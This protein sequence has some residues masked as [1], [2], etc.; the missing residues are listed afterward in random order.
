MIGTMSGTSADGVDGALVEIDGHGLSMVPRCLMHRHHPYAHGLREAIF[1]IRRSGRAS[2]GELAGLGREISL[3]CAEVTNQLLRESAL[4]AG[5]IEAVA[6]HGQTLYHHPPNTIQWL[7]PALLAARTRCAVISDFR[8][9]DCAAGGQGAPLVPFADF[10]LFRSDTRNRLLLNLGGIANVTYLRAGGKIEEVIAFDTGPANCIA[11]E[12]CRRSSINGADGVGYDPGGRLAASGRV[13]QKVVDAFLSAD[14][15]SNP[16]P[17]S[18][19]GPV[20]W[21]IWEKARPCGGAM[22]LEDEL[23]TACRITARSVALAVR[24]HVPG[25]PD[26]LLIGG[27]GGQNATMIS[28]LKDQL[29]GIPIHTLD[30]RGVDSHS[31]EAVCFALLG[32]A[33]LDRVAAN[34]PNATGAG[35]PVILG[36]ITPRP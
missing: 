18:T 3:A 30:E 35:Q 14:Y 22:T 26:E 16:P 7:D 15:F 4:D 31:R 1:S 29:E 11:D 36:C 13:N 20:M 32:A 23:A 19:D 28:M 6:A 25:R 27:G 24:N 17:K 9:A 5:R 8:R 34:I 12:L 10:I 21:S 2:L 33:T